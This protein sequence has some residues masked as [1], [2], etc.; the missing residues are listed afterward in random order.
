MHL[1]NHHLTVPVCVLVCVFVGTFSS[2]TRR[3]SKV[4][5]MRIEK[6]QRDSLNYRQAQQNL[7]YSDSL[8]QA[9]VVE[10][11]PLMSRFIYEK[12][13]KAEDHGHY[14][15]RTLRTSNNTSRNF[16][17]AYVMDNHVASVQSYYYGSSRHQQCKL[18]LSVGEN[19]VEREGSNHAFQ[20]EG[21]HEIL[22]IDHDDALHLLSFVDSHLRER[23]CAN[24]IGQQSVKYYLTDTEKQALSDTYRL[25]VSMRNIDALERAIHVANLQI[26]KYE[27]KHPNCK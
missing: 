8:L 27:K 13:D 11:D 6:N 21:W 5:Q 4:E 16:I 15:H 25:A 14:V 3:P 22:T 1:K 24:S 10:V 19:Y 17:Q 23:I 2:C 12:N 7:H 9:L 26:Q 18:R 20:A